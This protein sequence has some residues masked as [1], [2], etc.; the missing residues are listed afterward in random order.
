[1]TD[2]PGLKKREPP[3]RVRIKKEKEITF[4]LCCQSSKWRIKRIQI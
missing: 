2:I 3:A 4:G 1:M